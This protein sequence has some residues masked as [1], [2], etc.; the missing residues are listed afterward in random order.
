MYEKYGNELCIVATNVS[1]MSVEYFHPKTTPD[2]D[3]A[4]AVKCSSALPGIYVE[5]ACF[6]VHMITFYKL[7]LAGILLSM[8]CSIEI[9][10]CPIKVEIPYLHWTCI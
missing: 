10:S 2:V 1:T 4:L 8:A 6:N 5:Y 3:I 7:P 9:P